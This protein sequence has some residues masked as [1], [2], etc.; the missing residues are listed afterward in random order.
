MSILVSGMEDEH[1]FSEGLGRAI[2]VIRTGQDL[3]RKK[4]AVRAGLSYS[5][6]AEIE[7][8]A[9][10]PS[11]KALA[12]LAEALELAPHELLEAADRWEH[13]PPPLSFQQLRSTARLTAVDAAREPREP[14]MRFRQASASPAIGDIAPASVR[15]KLLRAARRLGRP[16]RVR[17][18]SEDVRDLEGAIERLACS[19]GAAEDATELLCLLADLEPEDRERLLDLARRLAGE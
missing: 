16:S 3:S 15:R 2:R 17:S 10:V 19:S 1:P 12:A 7:T 14:V 18:D 4:L 13:S 11:S 9:K 8:G 5:Y 6:L